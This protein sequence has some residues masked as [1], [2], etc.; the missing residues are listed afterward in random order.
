MINKT[1]ESLL[2][3]YYL[4]Q[5]SF[6]HIFPR[7]FIRNRRFVSV[8]HALGDTKPVLA[9]QPVFQ[10]NNVNSV[11]Q[12]PHFNGTSSSNSNSNSN[13]GEINRNPQCNAQG[14]TQACCGTCGVDSTNIVAD[15]DKSAPAKRARMASQSGESNGDVPATDSKPHSPSEATPGLSTSHYHF[16]T[17]RRCSPRPIDALRFERVGSHEWSIIETKVYDVC[18][19]MKMLALDMGDTP[20]CL[21]DESALQ[22]SSGFLPRKVSGKIG[23]GGIGYKSTVEG[24]MSLTKELTHN[25]S[26]ITSWT[27]ADRPQLRE[28]ACQWQWQKQLPAADSEGETSGGSKDETLMTFWRSSDTT[29]FSLGGRNSC[30]CHDC[31]DVDDSHPCGGKGSSRCGGC[32]GADGVMYGH[33]ESKAQNGYQHPHLPTQPQQQQLL[34]TQ[35]QNQNQNQIPNL[36]QLQ[37][38]TQNLTQN[39]NHAM[40]HNPNTNQH[41]NNNIQNQ[42]PVQNLIINPSEYADGIY[43]GTVGL[44]QP[45]PVFGN[46]NNEN[47]FHPANG[48]PLRPQ[49][50]QQQQ[51]QQQNKQQQSIMPGYNTHTHTH[52]HSQYYSRSSSQPKGYLVYEQTLQVGIVIRAN[53][54]IGIHEDLWCVLFPS[55]LSST[56]TSEP[57]GSLLSRLFPQLSVIFGKKS[58]NDNGNKRDYN[59]GGNGGAGVNG[60]DNRDKPVDMI[61]VKYFAHRKGQTLSSPPAAPETIQAYQ[62]VGTVALPASTLLAKYVIIT[63]HSYLST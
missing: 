1:F 47:M 2:W 32:G 19:F 30:L 63:S 42:N 12:T 57:F 56:Y 54:F 51:Q 45:S 41:Y 31:S 38:L 20:V 24:V 34:P 26:L 40:N 17:G 43:R 49:Q 61:V 15:D 11:S 18:E 36:N 52:A 14:T 3:I 22:K 55:E 7:Q 58:S 16:P 5:L 60:G 46:N 37:N 48:Q 9:S 39:P 23:F 13:S 27:K 25:N 50:Q 53:P 33:E 4:K 59:G 29:D 10:N 6:S 21:I 44:P 28:M 8:L 35:N 62:T